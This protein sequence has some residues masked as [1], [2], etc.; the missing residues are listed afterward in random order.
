VVWPGDIDNRLKT[1]LDELRIPE[2][3]ENYSARQPAA[4]EDPFFCLLEDDKLI[5]RI[6]V[7]T[8]DLLQPLKGKSSIDPADSRLVITVKIRPY[9]FTPY[10]TYFG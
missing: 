7:E 6:A 9:H 4:D 10:N 2:A 8:D 5:T 3:G 1:L